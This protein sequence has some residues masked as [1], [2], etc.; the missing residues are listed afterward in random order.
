[1]TF[2]RRSGVNRR[3][4]LFTDTALASR[5]PARTVMIQP[6]LED[7]SRFEGTRWAR[8]AQVAPS[9]F[10][11]ADLDHCDYAVL[12]F[13]W[14]VAVRDPGFRSA[15]IG[16]ARAAEAAGKQLLV[17]DHYD[18]DQSNIDLPSTL[19]FRTSMRR[20][21]RRAT[22]FAQPAWTDDLMRRFGVSETSRRSDRSRPVVGFCGYAPPRGIPLG[23]QWLKEQLRARISPT[24]GDRLGIS[25][26]MR[27]RLRAIESLEDSA[28]VDTDFIFR[29]STHV[30]AHGN[31]GAYNT[32]PEYRREFV[33][34]ML[35]SD[36]V[37]CTRGWGN[38]S[39][40]LYEALALGRVPIFV[41][42][43]CVLPAEDAIDWRSLCVWVD[44]CDIAELPHL[45]HDVHHS[46]SN[47]EL[48]QRQ[49]R[50]RTVWETFLSPH[51]FFSYLRDWLLQ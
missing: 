9:L 45:V 51:G 18:D 38:F 20:S 42:T 16:S 13:P 46:M 32:S 48:V 47:D 26:A 35:T 14:H 30:D 25:T 37:L 24:I 33:E 1:V 43:D 28:L 12:P 17:F 49:R 7:A 21:Q 31:V 29:N 4:K 22:E 40:R 3:V 39:F 6:L 19:V 34:N 11:L 41:D 15:A 27:A 10:E 8:Y 2:S 44:E 5:A 23:V 36:Y 50:C